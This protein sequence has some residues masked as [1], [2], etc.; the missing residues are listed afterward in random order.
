M[1]NEQ[2]DPLAMLR[3]PLVYR[4]PEMDDVSVRPDMS[5]RGEGE[6]QLRMDVYAPPA[7]G[8]GERRPAV[9]FVHGGPISPALPLAPTEWGVYRGYGALAAASGWIG[10]TFNHRFWGY[11]HL[12]TAADDI[13]AAVAYVREHADRLRVDADRLCLWAFSGGGPFLAD[14]LRVPVA[15]L[16]C[17]VAYYAVLDLRPLASA[18]GVTGSVAAETLRRFSPTA[19]VE[20]RATNPI[21]LLVARAGHDDP[22]LNAACDAFIQAALAAN[23]PL[24]ALNHPTGYHAF[25]VR[26]DDARTREILEHTLS[27][28]HAHLDR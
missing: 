3:A 27:F 7:L 6:S 10:V 5:Y 23:L 20:G 21:P 12:E 14:A 11:D 9:F 22:S 24:D 8:R 19:A 2:G 1:A 16:R 26:N 4:V 28:L 17:L 25:D 15:Y 13:A 18:E